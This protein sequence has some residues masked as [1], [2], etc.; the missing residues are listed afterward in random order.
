M[1]GCYVFLNLIVAV[2]LDTFTSLGH[3]NPNLVSAADVAMFT[4]EHQLGFRLSIP[5]PQTLRLYSTV[6]VPC[7]LSI[8]SI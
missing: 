5:R 1:L 7:T 6:P 8:F 4:G 2:M 3:S